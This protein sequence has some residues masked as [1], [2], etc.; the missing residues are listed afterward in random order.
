MAK[1]P[2]CAQDSPRVNGELEIIV[3]NPPTSVPITVEAIGVVWGKRNEGYPITHAY[4][5]YDTVAPGFHAEHVDSPNY[6]FPNLGYGKYK[7]T[8][9]KGSNQYVAYADYRDCD[10]QNNH[11]YF[12]NPDISVGIVSIHT[13]SRC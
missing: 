6:P 4:D 9:T 10:Y 11:S 7:I 5:R 1:A 8:V 13:K 3:V 2:V 12:I